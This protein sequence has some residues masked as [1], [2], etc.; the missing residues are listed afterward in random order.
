MNGIIVCLLIVIILLLIIIW[1]YQRQVKD[2]CRQLAFLREHDSNMIITRQIKGGGIGELTDL[3]NE[4]IAKHKKER[5]EYLDKERSIADAYT[6]LSHDIRTPLTSL[7]GYVQ[8]LSDSG[9]AKEQEYYL[10]IIRERIASL[11]DMLEELF[12]YTKL[13]NE[14][15][16]LELAPCVVNRI[17]KDTLFSYYEEWLKLGIEPEF[18]MTD[19]ALVIIGN[20]PALRRVTQN[21][22]KNGLDHGKKRIHISLQKEERQAVLTFQNEVENPQEIDLEQVFRR[23]Y[24][25]DPARSKNSSGLGLS[26]AAEFVKKMNGRIYAELA[27]NLF[28]I[29]VLFPLQK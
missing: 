15:Y 10:Q 13:K 16:Q 23:F 6:N 20:E 24:K 8:L 11:K 17:L 1:R 25:A 5:R 14:S 7:D 27:G 18:D 29:K 12:T 4:W 9:D 22:I 19:E 3:L 28:T 21:I 26:I 2:I